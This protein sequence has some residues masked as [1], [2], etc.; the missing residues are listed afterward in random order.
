MPDQVLARGPDVIPIPGTKRASAA[1]ENMAALHVQLS[2]AELKELEDA[3]PH[4][5]VR[6]PFCLLCKIASHWQFV[7]WR[8]CMQEAIISVASNCGYRLGCHDDMGFT[9][10]C[11]LP[12]TGTPANT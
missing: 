1:D 11:R 10:A 3:V 12:A 8:R 7:L 2:Q 9:H 6:Q 5:Q 4:H